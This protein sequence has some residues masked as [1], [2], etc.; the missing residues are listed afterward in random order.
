MQSQ[1]QRDIFYKLIER[2]VPGGMHE[3]KRNALFHETC[4]L[5]KRTLNY[6]QLFTMV[7]YKKEH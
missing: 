3:L 7:Y 2:S 4:K 6:R 1:F 5:L